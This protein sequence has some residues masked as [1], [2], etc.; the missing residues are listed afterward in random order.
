MSC[1]S[2]FKDLGKCK[3]ENE[4]KLFRMLGPAAGFLCI[5]VIGPV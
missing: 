1:N 4:L 3:V 2:L 5:G